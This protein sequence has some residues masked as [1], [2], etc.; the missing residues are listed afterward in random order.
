MYQEMRQKPE[1]VSD[2]TSGRMLEDTSEDVPERT[3]ERTSER[4][5]GERQDK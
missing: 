2:D 5:S 1:R 3:P 4:M